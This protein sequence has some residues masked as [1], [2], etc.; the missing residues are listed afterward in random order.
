VIKVHRSKRRHSTTL[1]LCPE[2]ADYAQT[3]PPVR[4]AAS[5]GMSS[6]PT[7][8]KR[9]SDEQMTIG[10]KR[11]GWQVA[12]EG[13][14]NYGTTYL[15]RACL[16]LI[17]LGANLQEDAIYPVTY[18]DA[19]GDPLS[20]A[21]RYVWHFEPDNMPPVLGFWSLTLYD[22]E[23]FQ[24]ANPLDR[25][26]IDD[27]DELEFNA[28]GS[29]DI[30]IQHEQPDSGSANW[31]PAPEV[32]ST[33]VPGSTTRDRNCSTATGHR[34]RWTRPDC[35]RL[36]ARLTAASGPP[37][38]PGRLWAARPDSAGGVGITAL[39]QRDQQEGWRS[40]A[41]SISNIVDNPLTARARRTTRL[42]WTP[43]RVSCAAMRSASCC[44][45]TSTPSPAGPMNVTLERSTIKRSG[46]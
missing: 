13:V 3:E 21:Q 44:A 14:G 42:P 22:A 33:C 35:R 19:D 17:G 8:R 5:F 46:C 36:E 28:D 4:R 12:A 37:R 24:D 30:R 32:G 27:R 29:L 43:I 31:L 1:R 25:F 26:A 39:L 2:T 16:E 20:G 9:I 18:V 41:F 15:R 7:S 45:Y 34:R 38:P 11:N 40:A 23:G 10:V 6:P